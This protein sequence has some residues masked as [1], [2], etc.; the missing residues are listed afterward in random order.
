MNNENQRL[1]LAG[2]DIPVHRGHS[3]SL[4]TINYS[5]LIAFHPSCMAT[6]R[7]SCKGCGRGIADDGA[8]SKEAHLAGA[9]APPA[10]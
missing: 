4:L 3:T 5:L 9:V 2:A 8:A 7:A 10:G 1:L 6:N